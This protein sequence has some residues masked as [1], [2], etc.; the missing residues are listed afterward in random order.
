M[1]NFKIQRIP[2]LITFLVALLGILLIVPI[3]ISTNIS[4]PGRIIPASVWVVAKQPDGSVGTIL[5]DY[6]TG[7]SEL[8][9]VFHADR[10]GVVRFR[11]RPELN[12]GQTIAQGD[13]LGTIESGSME[14][15]LA[16]LRGDLAV[17]QATLNAEASG[18]KAPVIEE[19]RREL[20][21]A[22][23]ELR[24]QQQITERQ[25]ALHEKN[26]VSS[27][28]FEIAKG[29]E[30]I[31]ELE[32]AAAEAYLTSV[33][34]GEK[35]EVLAVS[36]A[37]IASLQA[38]IDALERQ[39]ELNVLRTPIAGRLSFQTG[40]DTLML[41]EERSNMIV[42][43]IRWKY[44]QA[45]GVGDTVTVE[46][47]ENDPVSGTITRIEDRINMV[48]SEQVFPAY[49]Q[50]TGERHLPNRL[51]AVCKIEGARLS[52]IEYIRQVIRHNLTR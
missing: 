34:S 12:H 28:E 48:G 52:P 26:L 17:M 18:E 36:R 25:R 13:T 16:E 4:A 19:A 3:R 49:V 8:F 46:L 43:A 1:V 21:L 6:R 20:E 40:G 50:L 14:Q 33:R 29:R 35:P 5:R 38:Q 10:G 9:T 11:T 30:R 44:R 7:K 2:V 47:A 24:V 31:A 39:L 45:V 23:E 51:I 41:V 22:G 27:E 42:M 32:V 15:Q 37:E